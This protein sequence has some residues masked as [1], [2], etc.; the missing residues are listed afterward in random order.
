[1][2]IHIITSAILSVA[3]SV[4]FFQF[5]INRLNNKKLTSSISYKKLAPYDYAS[6]LLTVLI[7]YVF[8]WK[9]L[10]LSSSYSYLELVILSVYLLLLLFGTL[11]TV[12]S[13][14]HEQY[15]LNISSYIIAIA[16]LFILFLYLTYP[17]FLPNEFANLFFNSL[18]SHSISFIS[19]LLFFGGTYIINKD[20]IGEGDLL[21]LAVI[22]PTLGILN[23]ITL[24]NYTFITAA[25]FAIIN[26]VI[27]RD[28]NR[29]MALGPFIAL[30]YLAI[31]Y[32][33]IFI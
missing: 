8:I 10:W 26:L 32:Q 25:I 1:M 2:I 31:I 3:I 13:D 20:A 15:I 24:L 19:F 9:L 21:L 28:R 5:T 22:A 27:Y 16:T 12:I 14:I 29:H 33:H 6:L 7:T 18:Y 23:F 17:T 11:T 4:I 30:A